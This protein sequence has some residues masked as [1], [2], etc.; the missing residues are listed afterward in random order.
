MD[1]GTNF[2]IIFCGTLL[3]VAEELLRLGATV[4]DI[5]DK[6]ERALKKGLKILPS[7][8]CHEI[9]AI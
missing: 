4:K 8:V 3:Q 9:Y 5:C 7:F 6:Y 1:D 2:V